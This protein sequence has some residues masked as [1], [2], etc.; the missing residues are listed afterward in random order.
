MNKN[1]VLGGVGIAIILL[2]GVGV[3]LSIS[4][5]VD[6]E[7]G[8][9]F[10]EGKDETGSSE[11]VEDGMVK[12][13]SRYVQYAPEKFEAAKD[14]KRVYFFHASWCPT[15]KVVNE[16]FNSKSSS[17]PEDVVLFKTDYDTESA[18]KQ[19][20]GITYQHTFVQ[21]DEN[22]EEIAKW[23]GGGLNELVA[24]TR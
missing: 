9:T 22:G 1:L 18:L 3:F 16:E 10:M 13:G 8:D 23:N 20:F 14:K 7:M 4:N 12:D 5:P 17:I 15:C 21:V 24:N 11:V 19:K 2:V 6:K